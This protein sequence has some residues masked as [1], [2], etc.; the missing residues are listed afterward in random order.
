MLGLADPLAGR[1][2]RGALRRHRGGHRSR[3]IGD[4]LRSRFAS[5]A[6]IGYIGFLMGRASIG[7][8]TTAL[9]LPGALC[10]LVVAMG[11]ILLLARQVRVA[12]GAVDRPPAGSNTTI[13][14]SRGA[15]RSR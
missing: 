3:L 2:R 13:G 15:A 4:H 12:D 6:T 9:S 7:L 11:V 10:T 14:I 8:L 1:P 5:V